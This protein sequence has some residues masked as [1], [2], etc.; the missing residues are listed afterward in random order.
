MNISRGRRIA[1]V[2]IGAMVLAL[3]PLPASANHIND[4]RNI[5]LPDPNP[6]GPTEWSLR[7]SSETFAAAPRILIAR[8]DDFPDALASGSLQAAAAP[9]LLTA[10]TSLS[11]G[12]AEEADRLGAVTF[13]VIGGEAAVSSAVVDQLEDE[14][15]TFGRR[16]EGPTRF[17]TA[18]AIAE[19]ALTSALS[20]TVLILRGA[21]AGEPTQAFADSLAAGGWAAAE[22][23]PILLTETDRLHPA[24]E[25]FLRDQ[26]TI[27]R[28]IIV[29]GEAAVGGT[30]VAQLQALGLNVERVAGPERASTAIAVAVRRGFDAVADT[31]RFLAVEAERVDSYGLGFP[32]AAHSAVADAP[33]VLLAGGEIPA[34]TAAWLAG[35]TPR[36]GNVSDGNPLFICAA[37]PPGCAGPVREALGLPTVGSNGADVTLDTSAAPYDVGDTLNGGAVFDPDFPA[38]LELAGPCIDD[39][40]VQV[41]PDGAFTT[42]ITTATADDDSE[43]TC[44]VAYLVTYGNGTTQ[45]GRFAVLLANPDSGGLLPLLITSS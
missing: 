17:E 20:D 22:R 45:V 44:T 9:L 11:P 43:D 13:D 16:F 31:E 29:G 5:I 10:P 18:V 35:G 26:A 24:A 1:L 42:E 36:A 21:G 28:A 23:W 6:N 30:N 15:L 19:G 2:A 3:L 14:G 41:A 37:A 34:P 39:G 25:E 40:E 32:A 4:H 7:W 27:S 12:I 38:D 8:A 33:I